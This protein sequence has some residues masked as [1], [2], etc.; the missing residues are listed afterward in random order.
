MLYM[1]ALLI[2]VAAA[3]ADV[4]AA[5][6]DLSDVVF[7]IVNLL[8]GVSLG[9]V[10]WFLKK[11]SDRVDEAHRDVARLQAKVSVL[12]ERVSSVNELKAN[13]ADLRREF[14]SN[15]ESFRRDL[16]ADVQALRQEIRG[17]GHDDAT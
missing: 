16:R 14:L 2:A 3:Q 12:E 13:F 11:S 15:M 6:T 17:K 9:A 1:T 7:A 5:T 4:P 8:L 10:G